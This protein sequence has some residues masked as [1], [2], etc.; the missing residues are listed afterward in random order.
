MPTTDCEAKE[1]L[2]CLVLVEPPASTK[3]L[4]LRLLFV[5]QGTVHEKARE[6]LEVLV[7]RRLKTV[8][9][10]RNPCFSGFSGSSRFCPLVRP[11]VSAG[12]FIYPR[13]NLLYKSDET[14]V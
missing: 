2:Q 12:F 11:R 5:R 8:H 6:N 14:L 1:P 10:C 9:E 13:Y 3:R 4:F 7:T